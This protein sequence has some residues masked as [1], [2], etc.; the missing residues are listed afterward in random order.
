MHIRIH[1]HSEAKIHSHLQAAPFSKRQPTLGLLML[2]VT[3]IDIPPRILYTKMF[4]SIFSPCAFLTICAF[5]VLR[6][7]KRAT[8][9]AGG[10]SAA[11]CVFVCIHACVCLC[12]SKRVCVCV[13]LS[14]RVYSCVRVCVLRQHC[15]LSKNSSV[16]TILAIF[17]STAS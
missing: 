11:V 4:F 13:Y 1:M 7:T 9:N 6:G 17:S 16:G 10:K 2:A 14:V 3:F 12:V 15:N 5:F 8:Q